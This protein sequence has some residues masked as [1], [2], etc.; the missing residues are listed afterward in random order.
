MIARWIWRRQKRR[1]PWRRWP[2]GKW[3]WKQMVKTDRERNKK[4]RHP[5]KVPFFTLCIEQTTANAAQTKNSSRAINVSPGLSFFQSGKAFGFHGIIKPGLNTKRT[6][7]TRFAERQVANLVVF[8]LRNFFDN[9]FHGFLAGPFGR[10]SAPHHSTTRNEPTVF[11]TSSPE[12]VA[13][14][15][16]T[17][18]STYNPAPMMGESLYPAGHFK[19]HSAGGTRPRHS[20]VVIDGQHPNGIVVSSN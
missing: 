1:Q 15:P 11:I 18:P 2:Q 10:H 16:P 14:A 4:E 19:T 8:V 20:S 9:T 17:S 5:A 6:I 12:P 3:R 13:T 7:F